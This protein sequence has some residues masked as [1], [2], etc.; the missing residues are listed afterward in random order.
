MD[1]FI[2]VFIT[3][4]RNGF[5]DRGQ[6]KDYSNLDTFMF[7]IASL[8]S[9][10]FRRAVVN[11]ELDMAYYDLQDYETTDNMINECIQA[12]SVIIKHKRLIKKKEWS[13]FL[14]NGYFDDRIPIL[15][16]GNHDHIYLSANNHVLDCCVSTMQ[17]LQ[18]AG[19][20]I[21]VIL[22]HWVEYFSYRRTI[23]ANFPFGFL[24]RTRF[25]DSI[26]IYD[27]KLLKKWIN[28]IGDPDF[29]FRRLED[30]G[31]ISGN[32][33]LQIVPAKE[34][35]RHFDGGSHFGVTL[36]RV[37][38]LR[39][40]PGLFTNQTKI[41]I[42][43]DQSLCDMALYDSSDWYRIGPN[44]PFLCNEASGVDHLW[45]ELEIPNYILRRCSQVVRIGNLSED[46]LFE[47]ICS[48]VDSL[49]DF[50]DVTTDQYVRTYPTINQI[51]QFCD[52]SRKHRSQSKPRTGRSTCH[53]VIFKSSCAPTDIGF[54]LIL[55]THHRDVDALF[56][57]S[58][59]VPI[60]LVFY[61]ALYTGVWPIQRPHT[62]L[63][64]KELFNSLYRMSIIFF[65]FY[66]DKAFYIRH[67][68]SDI[69]ED[70]CTY[71][72]DNSSPGCIFPMQSIADFV[73]LIYQTHKDH[74]AKGYRGPILIESGK[75]KALKVT[76]GLFDFIPKDIK[77]SGIWE[78][79]NLSEYLFESVSP[80][81][82]FT[83]ISIS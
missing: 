80:Q 74:E 32:E 56:R 19:H 44:L 41:L 35:F 48:D 82:M 21:T 81:D 31:Y 67:I 4:N 6:L 66:F 63:V 29:E 83:R 72:I 27:L 38:P 16:S 55:G 46:I 76:K 70:G 39:I 78:S 53:H 60:S 18:S 64:S 1:L 9:I 58:L 26:A 43:Y 40:P 8:E 23:L 7:M 73:E 13:H 71:I 42:C 17:R 15:Y 69:L 54:A 3:E 65:D 25:R 30:L 62:D 20:Y 24:H 22:S 52:F 59:K 28:S 5:F 61:E 45:T 57:A 36:K 37:S 2:N 77:E 75:L 50:I 34:L 68:E 49:K 10:H 47:R 11:F 51:P 12:A 79:T 14:T 33:F